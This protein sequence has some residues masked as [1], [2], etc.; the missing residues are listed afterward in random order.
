MKTSNFKR[1]PVTFLKDARVTV[2][3]RSVYLALLT[4]KNTKTGKVSPS[5]ATICKH[6]LLSEKTVR[7]ALKHLVELGYISVQRQYEQGTRGNKTNL[8]TFLKEEI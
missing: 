6:A 3:D 7:K 5:V 4:F 1:I 8:Y 2:N